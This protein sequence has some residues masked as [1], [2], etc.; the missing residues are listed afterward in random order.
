MRLKETTH[1][2][3]YLKVREIELTDETQE[4]FYNECILTSGY[5]MHTSPDNRYVSGAMDNLKEC[6]TFQHSWTTWG[7]I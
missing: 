2:G 3:D 1:H 4:S 5:T 6:G 7:V